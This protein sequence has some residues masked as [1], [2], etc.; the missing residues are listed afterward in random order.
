MASELGA[1]ERIR[2]AGL[3]FTRR[4]LCLLSYT[5]RRRYSSPDPPYVAY[6][7]AR[8]GHVRFQGITPNPA[9]KDPAN[10]LKIGV[11]L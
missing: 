2:T 10:V 7:Q 1:G 5:G 9:P 4:L 11:V 8:Q 6:S 3:P